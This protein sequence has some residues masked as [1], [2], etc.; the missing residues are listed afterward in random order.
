[1]F[2]T[3]LMKRFLVVFD[4]H[5]SPPVDQTVVDVTAG[6]ALT[7]IRDAKREVR[8]HHGWTLARAIPW[9]RGC[10]NVD[11]AARKIAN[12]R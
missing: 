6:C 12:A 1:M 11:A 3:A 8:L 5:P 4:S 7:A 9:P 2:P 10:S